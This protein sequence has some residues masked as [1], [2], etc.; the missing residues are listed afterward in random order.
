MD[1]PSLFTRK[2]PEGVSDIHLTCG[3]R[4]II[5]EHGALR[6]LEEFDLLTPKDTEEAVRM[7]LSEQQFTKLEKSGEVDFSRFFESSEIHARINAYKQRGTYAAAIR[8]NHMRI[9]SMND[10]GLPEE[11]IA[12]F[13]LHTRGLILVTGPTG[14]GKSTTLASMVDW[15]NRNRNGHIITIE[16]PIE[17]YF[18]NNKCVI[19]QRQIGADSKT[20]ASALRSVLRQDPDVIVVGEMRDYESIAAALT[21]AETGHLVIS[22]LHTSG[23][24]QTIERIIDVFPAVQQQQ[25]RVQLASVLKCI[26]SQQLIPRIVGDG[27]VLASEILLANASVRNLILQDKTNQLQNVIITGSKEGMQTLDASLIN[28]LRAGLISPQ[29]AL[30][31]CVE[32][33]RIM[34][35]IKNIKLEKSL[36]YV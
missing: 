35:E 30:V 11:V 23:A 26:I 36:M 33:E 12:P 25:V 28:L 10:L 27:R 20:F 24:A 34:R 31:Y 16:D 15:I 1:I 18:K 3:S 8:I 2:Y 7:L 22:S 6:E 9:K 4:P 19:N 17:F 14:V 29:N 32:P 21:A 13:C 5:R